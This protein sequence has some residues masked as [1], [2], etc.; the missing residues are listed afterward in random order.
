VDLTDLTDVTAEPLQEP[1]A[2]SRAV[3]VDAIME[4]VGA[5][6]FA[7]SLA[8]KVCTR[9]RPATVPVLDN[10]AIYATFCSD[11]WERGTVPQVPTVWARGRIADAF[12]RV[13]L[14]VADPD[15]GW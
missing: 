2:A 15:N 3:V 10:Y 14:V 1:S 6:G 9:K 13:N 12:E 11:T 8:A 7:S 4:L 5:S